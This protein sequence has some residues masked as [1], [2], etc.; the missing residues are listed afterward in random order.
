MVEL[1]KSQVDFA[2]SQA[3]FMNEIRVTL[4]IQSSQFERLE[5]QV[6]QMAKI[7]VEEQQK[8][9]PAL[10]EPIREELDVKELVEVK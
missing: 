3:Q 7:L 5:V 1:A 9:L 8:S 2:D 4:Q 6:G 10:E